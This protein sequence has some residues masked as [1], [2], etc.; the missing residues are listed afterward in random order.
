MNAECAGIAAIGMCPVGQESSVL[1]ALVEFLEPRFLLDDELAIVH[2]CGDSPS[3]R[4]SNMRDAVSQLSSCD[5]LGSFGL[6]SE[7]IQGGIGITFRPNESGSSVLL[8]AWTVADDG[9][10]GL[11]ADLLADYHD[12]NDLVDLSSGGID[13]RWNGRR[14]FS[15][16]GPLV[17][18]SNWPEYPLMK[19][20]LG[21]FDT[22]I[23]SGGLAAHLRLEEQ[24]APSAIRVSYERGSLVVQNEADSIRGDR[25]AVLDFVGRENVPYL[26]RPD[27]LEERSPLGMF[28][29]HESTFFSIEAYEE[30][31]RNG[32]FTWK[33]DDQL[34]RIL[35]DLL[36]GEPVVL[37]LKT[38]TGWAERVLGEIEW[39]RSSLDFWSKHS[40][41]Y[42]ESV[43][44]AVDVS[45]DSVSIS[46]EPTADAEIT[47][48]FA[49]TVWAIS[50]SW[51]ANC[52]GKRV[53]VASIV[54]HR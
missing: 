11:A 37:E 13:R 3:V 19:R 26:T 44:V 45:D 21:I 52:D 22:T 7:S 12:L 28:W 17:P 46:F 30:G 2:F 53:Q 51:F 41:P 40:M 38:A 9:N 4:A 32:K 15:L 18:A 50:K 23:L 10:P 33:G 54:S 25:R 43:V 48:L 47:Q 29:C 1:A 35:A 24:A 27:G 39:S 20:I 34:D 8:E 31:V 5:P 14:E 6:R 16:S 49:R 42:L 36:L